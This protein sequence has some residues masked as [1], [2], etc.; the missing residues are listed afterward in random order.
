METVKWSDALLLDF[1]PMDDA[2]RAFVDLLAQ[3]QT[4]TDEALPLAWAA[5]LDHTARHFGQED[6]WMRETGFASAQNHLLQHRVVLNL[7]REGLAMAQ[8][9]QLAPVREMA[10]ELGSWFTKHTQAYDA[11]LAL[12]MRRQMPP[13][14]DHASGMG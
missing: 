10:S 8:A 4:A 9:G 1:A 14:P 7:L 11:A 3:A 12:H 5:V 6:A 2:H 13:G